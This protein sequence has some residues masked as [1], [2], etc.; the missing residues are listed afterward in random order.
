MTGQTPRTS[1][2]MS[3]LFDEAQLRL[4]RGGASALA[5]HNV[6]TFKHQHGT[7]DLDIVRPPVV[8]GRA[9]AAAM[10]PALVAKSEICAFALRQHPSADA[11]KYIATLTTSDAG[12]PSQLLLRHLCTQLPAHHILLSTFCAQHR[13]A[14][15]ITS[16]TRYCRLLA[17]A[18]C[19]AKTFRQPGFLA[20]LRKR[21]Q[22]DLQRRMLIVDAS[23]TVLEEDRR[24]GEAM[25]QACFV[26]ADGL[27]VDSSGGQG[28]TAR[29][30][31]QAC[32]F[33]A[34]FPGPWTGRSAACA[35]MHAIDHHVWVL[36][37]QRVLPC[38]G[39]SWAFSQCCRGLACS[40]VFLHPAHACLLKLWCAG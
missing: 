11:V 21:V 25:L 24:Y 23:Y 37:N 4:G 5:S 16:I 3:C 40:T 1:T 10:W 8:L 26:E 22:H 36:V 15:V 18:F 12:S 38:P 30:Q 39:Y 29:R 7:A 19:T 27:D 9:N 14:S 17:S 20:D 33:L 32:K 6:V 2:I 35:G 34:F 28:S 31:R 13:T